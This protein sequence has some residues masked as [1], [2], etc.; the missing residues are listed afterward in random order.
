MSKNK[1]I[2]INR[3]DIEQEDQGEW[4]EKEKTQNKITKVKDSANGFTQYNLF[5]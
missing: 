3:K 2:E 4:E 5:P 1:L